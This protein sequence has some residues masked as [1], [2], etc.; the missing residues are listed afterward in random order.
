[1]RGWSP[2]PVVRGSRS[3]LRADAVPVAHGRLAP[4]DE[5]GRAG[6]PPC[7]RTHAPARRRGR[8][9]YRGAGPPAEDAGGGSGAVA[10]G[11]APVPTCARPRGA[12]PSS[13][14]A[15]TGE[16]SPDS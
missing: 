8:E 3:P 9:R 12:V 1:G 10:G 5:D 11:S 6:R 2:T 14:P 7:G 15:G 16:R 13:A 4:P